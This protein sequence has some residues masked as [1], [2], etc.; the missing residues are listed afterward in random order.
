LLAAYDLI[1]IDN[2][3]VNDFVAAGFIQPMDA[4]DW[5]LLPTDDA[6]DFFTSLTDITTVDGVRYGVPFYDCALGYIC[7]TDM[8][9]ADQVPTSLDELVSL[10]ASLTK[11]D[12]A[13]LAMQPRRVTRVMEEWTDFLYSRR[14]FDLWRGRQG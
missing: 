2:S 4:K 12:R 11:P 1:A 9:S 7:N 5:T 8:V 10:S 14:W 3:W 6:A 13:G